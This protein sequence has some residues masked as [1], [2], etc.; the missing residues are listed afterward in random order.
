MPI[1]NFLPL[2]I[3]NSS[4]TTET[5]PTISS[6][7]SQPVP[8]ATFAGW[9]T[10]T[11]QIPLW[12]SA[13]AGG[14]VVA[15][16]SGTANEIA[17]TGTTN[18]V[19]S[20]AAPS[21]APTPGSYT[22]ANITVD[23]FG[24]VTAAEDGSLVPPVPAPTPG[25]Y[26]NANITVDEFGRVTAAADGSAGGV[27]SVT[28]TANEI[29]VTTGATPVVSLA[30]PSPA[31]SAGSYTNA[32]IT[33]DTFGRV[34]EASS[35]G[36]PSDV[37]QWATFPA[38]ANVVMG[39][40]LITT[41]GTTGITADPGGASIAIPTINLTSQGGLGGVVNITAD[42][43]YAGVSYG[44]VSINANGGSTGDLITG[45]L[46]EINANTPVGVVPT[47]TSAIK[48]SG[49]GI[50][51]YAG[52]IPSIGSLA[53]YNFI[54]GTAGV[55]ICAGTPS[56]LPNTGIT[57]YLY[58]ANGIELNSDVYTTQMFPFWNGITADIAPLT[59][60]GRPAVPGIH[61]EGVV[62]LENVSTINGNAYPPVI[63]TPPVTKIIAGDSITISPT[64]GLGDVTINAI[65]STGIG[66]LPLCY[67][68]S[69][70]TATS[71]TLDSVPT[72][73]PPSV[74]FTGTTTRALVSIVAVYDGVETGDEG[75][76]YQLFQ[77]IVMNY[78][79]GSPA[80]TPPLATTYLGTSYT[81]GFDTRPAGPGFSDQ[82]ITLTDT[83]LITNVPVGVPTEFGITAS[84]GDDYT[85]SPITITFQNG[86]ISVIPITSTETPALVEQLIAGSNVT[87]SPTGG[88]G[89]VT[90]TSAGGPLM[91]GIID[92]VAVNAS[93]WTSVGT[94]GQYQAQ[95]SLGTNVLLST[96]IVIAT[97]TNSDPDDADINWIVN[98]TPDVGSGQLIVTCAG[99]PTAANISI[100]WLITLL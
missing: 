10:I 32:N 99:N 56:V 83:F 85:G 50:N 64:S 29:S 44:R 19:I 72:K 55:N 49:A 79:S 7:P 24:R 76:Q 12:A 92:R 78:T 36:G 17:V 71:V 16:V 25:S 89:V 23:E 6:Q 68:D 70:A 33:I 91:T 75:A 54:Y 60:S 28:G 96:S 13:G 69:S 31:P 82:L 26:T 2:P 14:N 100:A 46:I 67:G 40:N 94:L 8:S 86:S 11:T 1:E 45:G 38:V 65:P 59:I 80:G 4:A 81:F 88:Q 15:S 42:N 51:S 47:V 41:T 62:V 52:A 87:L 63:P 5:P 35:G 93:A 66:G 98:T 34:T 43:G 30:V 77:N 61:G 22:S 84:T 48:L 58:G 9:D 74:T 90:V 21:P 57:T 53:G 18:P 39:T 3:K 27:T 20:L 95:F 73:M 97:L 37:S